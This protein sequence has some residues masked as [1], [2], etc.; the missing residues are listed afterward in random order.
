[1]LSVSEE[2]IKQ[3]NPEANLGLFGQEY[4]PESYAICCSDCSDLLIKDEPINSNEL[5][6]EHIAELVRLYGDYQHNGES[7]VSQNGDT[8]ERVCSKLFPNREFGFLKIT[9]ERSLR[10]NFQAS[11]ERSRETMVTNSIC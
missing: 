10:L 9:V 3:Q 1:M 2:Y 11:E 8:E 6:A 7:K 5:S 4:N